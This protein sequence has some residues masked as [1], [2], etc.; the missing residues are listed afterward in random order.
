LIRGGRTF[1]H[2]RSGGQSACGGR[3]WGDRF[4][5]NRLLEP[6]QHRLLPS[7]WRRNRHQRTQQFYCGG[8]ARNCCFAHFAALPVAQDSPWKRLRPLC[9]TQVKIEIEA[10]AP[11]LRKQQSRSERLLEL[12]LRVLE[13][14][15]D[16]LRAPPQHIRDIIVIELVANAQIQ[17]L[18]VIQL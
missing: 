7:G 3:S 11:P 4:V 9:V 12:G 17:Q 14:P 15:F 18:V 2:S 16:C 6:V 10:L 1:G 8:L 13:F 5:A